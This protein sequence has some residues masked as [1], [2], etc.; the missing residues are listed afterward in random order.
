MK[1]YTIKEY[2][3]MSERFNKLSF[4]DKIKTV[5]D[6]SNIL[7]LASDHNWWGVKVKNEEIQEQLKELEI[8]FDIV[9]EWDSNEIHS[10]VY[11]LGMDVTDI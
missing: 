7:T 10:L 1:T 9:N 4:Q 11:L 2:T 8:Y 5:R 6:N 3:E